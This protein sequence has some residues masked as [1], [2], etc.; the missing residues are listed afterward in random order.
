MPIYHALER[1][2]RVLRVVA[3]LQATLGAC[4]L[5]L[6]VLDSSSDPIGDKVLRAIWNALNLVTT[7]GDFGT[8][9]QRAKV[10]MMVTMV[11]F[12]VVGGYAISSL[13]GIFSSTAMIALRENRHMQHQLDRLANHVIVGGF[14]AVGRLV[15]QQMQQ[16]GV[17]VVVVE[18]NEEMAAEA[19]NLGYLVVKGDA[20][21]SP[22]ALE[23]ARVGQADALVVTTDNPDRKLSI[24]LMAHSCNP[25]LKILVTGANA[26]RGDLLRHAGASEVVVIDELVADALVKRLGSAGMR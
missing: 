19:S 18:R 10:F 25:Q 13:T 23:G 7:L 16:A 14:G 26:P 22:V 5:G 17:Q 6:F 8:L 21:A 4:S 15:A 20:G 9:D 24:T 2:R 1:R 12:M 3:L 11:A